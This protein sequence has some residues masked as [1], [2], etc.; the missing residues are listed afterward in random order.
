MKKM[1]FGKTKAGEEAF[2]YNISRPGLCVSVTDYGACIVNL[3]AMD[4]EGNAIDVM[5]GYDDV[6]GYEAGGCH[7]GAPVGRNANRIGG[8]AFDIGGVHYELA[9]NNNGNNLHSGPD[10]YEKRI[11]KVVDF[12]DHQIAFSLNSPDGDQGYPGAADISMTYEVTE[13]QMLK[14]SYRA[15][16]DKDTIINMTNHSYFNLNGHFSG[17]ILG[18]TVVLDADYFTRADS[19]AIP[20]GELVDVTGTPMDF[21]SGRVIGDDIDSDYEATRLGGGYDHNWVL[22]NNGRFTK[23]AEFIGD[24]SKIVMEVYTDLP[25][26]QF[27]TGNFIKEENGKADAE[28]FKRSGA[29][30]E[31]QYFPDAIHHD[32]F[33][34]PI[35]K[36]GE[37]YKTSTGY[38]FRV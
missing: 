23:V 20:T 27:Y 37:E 1:S 38:R 24:K 29:C 26:I 13:D 36:A 6:S 19:E 35:C 16:S 3:Y 33:A 15:V 4:Q 17:D 9:K 5:L 12:N 14:I 21:R 30:F 32:N 7:F 28:Y 11:W 25:G 2:L 22:K 18:H 10:Y 31:T 8:A 34:G